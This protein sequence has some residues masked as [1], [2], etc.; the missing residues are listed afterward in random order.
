M[1]DLNENKLNINLRA[2]H[3]ILRHIFCI[4]LVYY[5]VSNQLPAYLFL[6]LNSTDNY[7]VS[8]M[9]LI[10]SVNRAKKI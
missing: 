6:F 7:K 1:T 5:Y 2:Y 9:E 3:K 8:S 4:I 10:K